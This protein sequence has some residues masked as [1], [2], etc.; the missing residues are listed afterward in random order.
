MLPHQ[1]RSRSEPPPT[2]TAHFEFIAARI[3]LLPQAD[4]VAKSPAEHRHAAHR[5]CLP[6][7]GLQLVPW[8][9]A[10]SRAGPGRAARHAAPR[11][12]RRLLAPSSAVPPSGLAG[13][14]SRPGPRSRPRAGRFPLRE[15]GPGAAPGPQL[16]GCL[17]RLVDSGLCLISSFR[18][19]ICRAASRSMMR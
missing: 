9:A 6:S 18:V 19:R 15:G 13:A 3:H 1:N 10:M 16:G 8:A 2:P 4:K 17:D 14:A 12:R 11:S 5:C 7:F